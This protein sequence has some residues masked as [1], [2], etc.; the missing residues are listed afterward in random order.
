MFGAHIVSPLFEGKARLARHRLVNTA[1]KEQIKII[2]AWT[3]K[4]YSPKE[5]E[6]EVGKVS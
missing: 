5:W 4:C 6:K 3:P 2:H 1:L